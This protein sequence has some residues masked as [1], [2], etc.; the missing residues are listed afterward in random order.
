MTYKLINSKTKEEHIC[1]KIII[2]EFDYYVSNEYIKDVRPYKDKW[3]IE[4]GIILNKF[5][6]Y[7]TDLSECK[8]IV[9]TN[10]PNIDIPKVIGEIEK[11]AMDILKNKW[12][13]LYIFGY[14]KKPYPTN[15]E[16]D[17]NCTLLGL[18]KSQTFNEKDMIEFTEWTHKNE[19]MLINEIWFH[20][21]HVTYLS[22]KDLL[23]IWKKQQPKIIFYE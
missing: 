12:P 11:F 3:H 21:G 20:L 14:P 16:N 17:L 2:E 9:A 10:N 19:Y 7:L 4:K 15:Y 13:H 5:P 22:T 6:T 23:Q 18:L 1:D 8:L